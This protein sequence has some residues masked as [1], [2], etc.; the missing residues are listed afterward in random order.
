M[1]T[2]TETSTQTV[3]LNNGVEMP[4]LGFGVFQIPDDQTQA[5]LR[6]LMNIDR[7][8]DFKHAE[9]HDTVTTGLDALLRAQFPSGGFPQVWTKPVAP[10]PVVSARHPSSPCQVTNSSS[11]PA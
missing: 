6:F 8:L 7:A 11:A 9:I 10:R 4:I 1:Q 5:A 2:T 3:T